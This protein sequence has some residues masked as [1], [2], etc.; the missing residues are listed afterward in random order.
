M[1]DIVVYKGVM[2][3]LRLQTMICASLMAVGPF[4]ITMAQDVPSESFSVQQV[5][6]VALHSV[7]VAVICI[8]GL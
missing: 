1:S 5:A 7:K 8:L 2:M 6:P 4:T 3:K